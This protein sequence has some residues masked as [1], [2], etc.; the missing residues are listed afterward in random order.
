MNKK[1]KT[2]FDAPLHELDS[3]TQTYGCRHKNPE[4]CGSNSLLDICA[5]TTDD[6]ICRKPLRAWKRQ[7]E[8]LNGNIS[9]NILQR[10]YEI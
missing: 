10:G 1:L 4:I 8:L 2:P 3:E 9:N 6:C 5:F 7:Y